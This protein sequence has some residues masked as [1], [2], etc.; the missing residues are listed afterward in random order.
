MGLREAKDWPDP[1]QE[2]PEEEKPK[3]GRPSVLRPWG[4]EFPKV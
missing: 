3:D 2:S 4:E 1:H